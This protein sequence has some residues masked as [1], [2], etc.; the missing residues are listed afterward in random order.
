MPDNL[1]IDVVYGAR[2]EQV[3][4][5]VSV[6]PGATVQ[7]AL[8]ASGLAARFPDHRLDELPCGIWGKVAERSRRL[9]AGDRV[10]IYRPLAMDP[11]EARRQL[12]Q[13]GQTMGRATKR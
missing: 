6:P 1:A 13:S 5:P 11:R 12:A 7:D 8:D 2:D 10:E 9:C 3:I 4:T